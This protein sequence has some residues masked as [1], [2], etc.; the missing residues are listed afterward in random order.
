MRTV[1]ILAGAAALA[2]LA[3]GSAS[4]TQSGPPEK[5]APPADLSGVTV[6]P[7]AKPNPLNDPARAFV[8]EHLPESPFSEQYP[9]FHDPVCVKVQG[10]PE[11]FNSFIAK[12][13]IAVAEQV[14][15]PIAKAANCTPNVHVIFS[16]NPQAQLTDIAKRRDILIGYQFAPQL[17]RMAKFTHP[18][19]AR[20][21]TR[22]VGDNG[23]SALDVFDPDRYD[24][25]AGKIPPNG[26]AGSRL[27]NGMSAEIVHSLI[28]ADA[29]KV[30]DEKIGAVADYVAVLALARWQGLERCNAIPTILN[31]MAADCDKASAPEAATPADFGL[32]TGLYSVEPREPAEQQRAVIASALRKANA[33]AH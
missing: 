8:R 2:L 22:S 12:R 25:A 27:G 28:L 24:P 1:A 31:L 17:K 6:T 23:V 16:S 13:I 15:A 5:S 29:T 18:I 3:A 11:E 20:Y 10:L 9:R 14:R 19:E 4:A 33:E 21:V 30:A 26:R 7:E 32:L